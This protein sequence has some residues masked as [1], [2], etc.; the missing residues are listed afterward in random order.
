MYNIYVER[1][2]DDE[3]Y[4]ELLKFIKKKKSIC[5]VLT[6]YNWELIQAE[7][8]Y[9]GTRKELERIMI[10][11]YNKLKKY[12][13][14]GLHLHISLMPEKLNY[15]EQRRIF[16]PAI[17][18]M[19]NMGFFK[20]DEEKLIT[21]GWHKGSKDSL[22]LVKKYGLTLIKSGKEIHDYELVNLNWKKK[23]FIV[24]SNIFHRLKGD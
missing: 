19:L 2:F 24:A 1:I 15:Y 4:K 21:F 17:A 12:A 7:Q 5:F 18:W 8:R 20:N 13:K 22:K 14:I 10:E 23:G 6:P 11:R 9:C 3:V 16:K